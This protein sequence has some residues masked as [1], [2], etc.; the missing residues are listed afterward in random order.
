MV[1]ESREFWQHKRDGWVFAEPLR[2]LMR[3]FSDLRSATVAALMLSLWLAPSAAALAGSLEVTIEQGRLSLAAEGSPLAEVLQAIG[4]A[5]GFA[6]VLRGDLGQPVDR[7]VEDQPLDAILQQL[8]QGHSLIVRR[9]KASGALTEIRVI[10]SRRTTP[11]PR[12]LAEP[13]TGPRMVE[14]PAETESDDR[15]GGL[16]KR[17]AFRLANLGMPAPTEDDIR[18]ALAGQD[19]AERVAAIPKVG[20]LMPADALGVLEDV[21]AQDEDPL[22]RSRAVAA[23]TRFGDSNAGGL[24]QAAALNDGDADIRM[25]A[26]NALAAS[27]EAQRRTTAFARA[28]RNDPDPKVRRSALLAMQRVGGDW[29]RSYLERIVSDLEPELRRIA[30][31]A[32]LTWPQPQ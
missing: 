4:E 20:S 10:A 32:L 19:Q 5:G 7:V 13:S 16:S 8:A 31:R 14:A 15:P 29:G 24:L 9:D 11:T 25:Q 3:R 26:I 23:L 1:R 27:P 6:V 12:P 17:E 18:L 21:L 22:V 30:D 2:V 28:L